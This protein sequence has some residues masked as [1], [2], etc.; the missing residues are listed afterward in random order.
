M[1]DAEEITEDAGEA[2]GEGA[3]AA[4]VDLLITELFDGNTL[5]HPVAAPSF[6]SYGGEIDALAEQKR[7]LRAYLERVPP[8]ALSRLS[9]PRGMLLCQ[10]GV[11]LPL[12]DLPKKLRNETEVSFPCALLPAVRDDVVPELGPHGK[13]P[14]DLWVMIPILDHIFYIEEGEI[15]GAA[16]QSEVR[17]L[18]IAQGLSARQ[19]VTHLPGRASRL[20]SVEVALPEAQRAGKGA[21]ARKAIIERAR[22]KQAVEALAAVSTPLH[23]DQ[24]RRHD[25]P[26]VGRASELSLLS[27]LLEGASRLGV[28]LVGA[29]N[30][31]KSALFRAYLARAKRPVYGSSGAQLIAG[32]SGFGQWQERIRA[33]M[34]G[35][36]TLD[37]VLY[38][39]SLE[40]LLAERREQGG[41]DLAGAMRPFL[42]EG[43]VRI[44]AEIRPDELDRLEGRSYAFFAGMTRIKIAPLSAADARAALEG[45]AARDAKIEPHRPRLDPS[46]IPALIDL[47]ERYLPYSAFPGKAVRLYQDLRASRDRERGP[48]GAPPVLGRRDVYQFFSLTTGVPEILLR[49]DA[50]LRIADVE[51]TLRRQIIGQD[52]AIRALAETVGVVKAGLQPQNKPLATF[53]F[54]GPTGVGKT[55]LSRALAELL[56]GSAERLLRFD[57]SEFM[58]PDAAERLIRGTDRADG[59]LTR[60]VRAQPFC[61]ILLDEIEKAHPAV[62]DLLLQVCGEGRLSDARGKTAY[63]HNAIL[64]LTSNL[65]ARDKRTPAGFGGAPV[66]DHAH[67]QKLVGA[68]FRQEMVNRLDRIVPFRALGRGEVMQVARLALAKIRRRRGLDEASVTLAVSEAA[69]ERLAADGYS[70]AYGARALRR[71]LDEHLVGPLARLLAGLGDGARDLTLWVGLGDEPAPKQEG[72]SS[73]TSREG[74]LRFEIYRRKSQGVTQSTYG[75][76]T[77]AEVRRQ[78]DGMMGLDPVEQV[79]D[80]IDFLLTQLSLGDSNKPDPRR[81]AELG[82][83]SAEHHRLSELYQKLQSAQE[84]ARSV[85]ELAMMALFE[86]EDVIPLLADARAAEEALRRALPY[87][88]T[89]LEPRRDAITM[90]VEELDAGAFEEWLVPL[91]VELPKRGWGI[92]GHIEGGERLTSDEWPDG[93]RWGP[94]RTPAGL[95]TALDQPKRSFRNVLLRIKG[96]YAGIFLALEAGL[97]RTIAPKRPDAKSSDGRTHLFVHRIALSAEIRDKDWDHEALTPPQVGSAQNRKKGAATRE[98]DRIEGVLRFLGKRAQV[99]FDFGKYWEK[100]DEIALT[101]L[102][103]FEEEGTDLDRDEWLPAPLDDA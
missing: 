52:E 49:D 79:K 33:V 63:F 69:M 28:L 67:Y 23:L 34:E 21:A 90:V 98:R 83:L 84:E 16:V 60:A 102:L 2:G 1:S 95:R 87:V 58:T 25:P 80:Q 54:V 62:F 96:P 17:R 48:D 7:F 89:A 14:F 91:L 26:L 35:V 43:K 9:L 92:L 99:P 31:G 82:E 15:V 32:M 73:G 85:E 55:E 74:P 18:M 101:H 3:R 45:R 29:E 81:A 77:I 12:D 78:I 40:D 61:V 19:M 57:M 72:I 59:L 5:I 47:S 41:A 76:G 10:I 86:G 71:H 36:E 42:E 11:P 75:F 8:E 37:A 70:A 94:P 46:A 53:L 50:P 39:E 13:A 66:D 64:I 51:A 103:L 38:F 100:L 93:R 6:A 88:L 24:Q 97:H 30:T 20:T 22:R 68:T 65:G 4:R 44:V 56:F 27:S